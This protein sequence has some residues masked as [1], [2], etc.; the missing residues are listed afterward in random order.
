[1]KLHKAKLDLLFLRTCLSHQLVPTFLNFKLY[2]KRITNSR[3]YRNYQRKLL[4]NEIKKKSNFVKTLTSKYDNE[5][6]YFRSVVSWLDFNHLRNLIETTNQKTLSRVSY[7]HGRKLRKLGYV[8]PNPTVTDR[9]IFNF[10]SHVLSEQEKVTL[11]K[12]LKFSFPVTKTKFISHFLPFERLAKILENFDLFN[13][14]SRNGS[15]FKHSL[16]HIALS[17]FYSVSKTSASLSDDDVT[18]LEKLK[19]NSNIVI[20]KPDKGNGIV[21]LDKE[22]YV[23]KMEDILG[24][25]TKFAKLPDNVFLLVLK[26][27]DKVNNYLRSLKAKGV[28]D[29]TT[30][31]Q[32]HVSGAQPGIMYG[33]PKV[34]KHG[35]PL[36]LILSA[37]LTFNYRLAKFFVP[38]LTP[39]TT[40]VFTVKD[41]FSF[42]T[43]ISNFTHNGCVMASFEIKSLFTNIP[44]N[45]TIDICLDNIF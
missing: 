18:T 43:E 13:F 16:K 40:N 9:C 24:D 14:K 37:L 22:D 12:G 10:S 17:S 7:V 32:L 41:S 6:R 39:I 21:L 5:L 36:H 1:M 20:C 26:Q 31:S 29:S 3:L 11:T 33:L 35:C 8:K 30:F 15:Y 19:S 28:I 23:R 38:I 42:A 44:L 34:H 27:E 2:D 25:S 4:D 45:G